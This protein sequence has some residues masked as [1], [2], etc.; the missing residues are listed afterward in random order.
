MN[1]LAMFAG[2]MPQQNPMAALAAMGPQQPQEQVDSPLAR[3]LEYAKQQEA[4]LGAAP[5][6]DATIGAQGAAA[7][8]QQDLAA[9]LMNQ[10]YVQDSGALGALAQTLSA[11]SGARLE[12]KAGESLADAMQR[13]D[14]QEAAQAQYATQRKAF[15]EGPGKIK[16]LAERAQALGVELSPE[17]L[18]SG[19]KAKAQQSKGFQASGGFT[20]N[21]DT[22]E[23]QAIPGYMDA[24]ERIAAAGRSGSGGGG[25]GGASVLS[26]EEAAALGLAPGT[27]AQRDGKGKVSVLQAPK[28]VAS[29]VSPAFSGLAEDARAFAAAYTGKSIE[30]ISAMSPEDIREAVNAGGRTMTGPLMGRI[31]GAGT[32]FNA[33]LEAYSNAAAGK[34]A[35]L[36][37]PTGPVSNADFE[38][39]RKSVW[40]SEKPSSVNADLIFQAISRGK[41]APPAAAAAPAID[42]LLD[43]YK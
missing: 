11:F 21:R 30:E 31:P 17:E 29:D 12:R 38:I 39:G 16:A 3:A 27:V 26:A 42:D 25:G 28:A 32:M 35:R 14:A 41:A 7:Q 9:A 36:N 22:G 37:N 8:R 2:Q 18:L 10:G 5:V 13:Q 15:D 33:D 34:Q 20:I 24:R 4:Q 1:P 19:E 23:S 43:K 6:A 40:S